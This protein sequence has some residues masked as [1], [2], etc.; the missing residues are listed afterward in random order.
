ME[1]GKRAGKAE[2]ELKIVPP[3]WPVESIKVEWRVYLIVNVERAF[4]TW[5][6]FPTSGGQWPSSHEVWLMHADHRRRETNR[7]GGRE[8][9]QPARVRGYRYCRLKV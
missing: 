3:A 9:G 7:K 8:G 1:A 6:S 2:R 4:F 5:L